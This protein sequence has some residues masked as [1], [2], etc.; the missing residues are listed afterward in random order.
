M[1]PTVDELNEGIH[2]TFRFRLLPLV[3][4]S[5]FLSLSAHAIDL[6]SAYKKATEYDS[7][8][9]TAL[10][11]RNASAENVTISRSGLLPQVALGGSVTHHDVDKD[12][13]ADDSYLTEGAELSLTQPILKFD[14]YHSYKASEYSRN[15][16]DAELRTA[17]QSLILRTAQAYFD[18]LRAWDDLT[19]AKRAE[20]AFKRQWEQA[21]ERFEVGLIAIT[22]VHE[23][24]ATYDSGKVSRINAQGQLDVAL[25]TLERITGEYFNRIQILSPDF[26]VAMLAPAS[27]N[28]WETIAFENNPQL[29]AT[30]WNVQSADSNVSARKAGH[31][32]TLN[33]VASYAYSD[34]NGPS[35]A[36]DNSTDASIAL[37]LT[38][39][40][41]T[42]G[43]TQAG[44]RQAR[45]QLEQ[46]QETLNTTQR[47]IRLQ[48]RSLYRTLQ[49]NIEA[50]QARK[51]EIVSNE[52]ALQA[53]RAGYDVGTRNI[54]EVLDAERRYFESLSNYANARYD[55][56]VNQLSF[57]QTAG[58][59]SMADIEE[60][61]K[62]LGAPVQVAN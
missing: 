36:D 61:N 5:L 58:V 37:N 16:A 59:L 35:P 4:S 15:Q 55:F 46:A 47:N 54:V 30:R 8:L 11:A 42:G 57:K 32:P 34:Y 28:E 2:M 48:L 53:T 21:K 50:I 51:Q 19:T 18:V 52:S 9:A 62:W 1:N 23:S 24:K 27:V 14:T 10:A 6:S 41:Y 29:L 31:Y 38:V 40:L 13:G 25:E 44:V 39:P 20:E 3:A 17:E 45:Y 56:V 60:L 33:A 12:A 22:E 49:T 43:G 7:E 26:P